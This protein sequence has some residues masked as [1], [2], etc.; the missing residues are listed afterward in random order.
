MSP[1]L[2]RW[3]PLA[4]MD[5]VRRRME[6]MFEQ[7]GSG[8]SRS[9][10]LSIDLIERD[11]GYVLR[12]DVPGLKPDEISIEIQDDVL[13]VS[14]QHEE[15]EEEETENYIRRERRYGSFTRSISLPKG[16]TA[17]DV[18]ASYNDGVLEVTFPKA[19]E[20]E[21]QA[22]TITPKQG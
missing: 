21:P 16:V 1:T 19:Q 10:A 4:E 14:A 3:R 12:A 8:E 5:E 11:D 18:E 13:T 20:H 17:D 22:V 6:Q 9:W 7:A 2:A 15:K